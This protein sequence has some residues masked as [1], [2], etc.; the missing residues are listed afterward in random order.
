MRFLL[1]AL[2]GLVVWAGSLASVR[3]DVMTGSEREWCNLGVVV[4]NFPKGL[5]KHRILKV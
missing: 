3:R 1:P 4:L 2:L 5:S